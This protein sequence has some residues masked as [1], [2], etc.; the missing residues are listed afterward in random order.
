MVKDAGSKYDNYSVSSKIRW[1]L[2]HWDYELT[3]DNSL[4]LF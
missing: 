1:I 3:E 4:A 2:L